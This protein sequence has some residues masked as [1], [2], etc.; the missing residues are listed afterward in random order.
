VNG[1]TPE[2]IL[3]HRFPETRRNGYDILSV[4]RYLENLAEYVAELSSQVEARRDDPTARRVLVDAQQV[5]DEVVCSARSEAAAIVADAERARHEAEAQAARM[6]ASAQRQAQQL[7]DRSF[8]RLQI[9]ERDAQHRVRHLE[10]TAEDLRRFVDGTATDL[11]ARAKEMESLADDLGIETQPGRAGV[12]GH[13][14]G[15][16]RS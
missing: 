1:F 5:A 16:C 7:I 15:R 11:R 4:D 10:R 8:A 9:I 13:E 6:I 3:G 14:P 12:P 2:Q